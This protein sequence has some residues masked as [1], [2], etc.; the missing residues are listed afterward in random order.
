MVA[1]VLVE[2]APAAEALVLTT[3]GLP[4]AFAFAADMKYLVDNP[5]TVVPLKE[6]VVF[7]R[8]AEAGC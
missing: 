5:K 2:E 7:H 6:A 4:I 1:A 3:V 8:E